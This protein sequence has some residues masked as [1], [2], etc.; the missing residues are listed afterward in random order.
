MYVGEMNLHTYLLK[1]VMNPPFFIVKVGYMLNTFFF[2]FLFAFSR[3]H[4]SVQHQT[5]P[6]AIMQQIYNTD[7]NHHTNKLTDSN[8][9]HKSHK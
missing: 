7:Q 8:K 2:F 9:Q 6:A 4:V 5:N 1:Q 3:L